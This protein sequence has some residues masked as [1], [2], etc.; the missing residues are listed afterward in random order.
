MVASAA[1]NPS[2]RSPPMPSVLQIIRNVASATSGPIGF[3]PPPESDGWW[4]GGLVAAAM[5]ATVVLMLWRTRSLRRQV[6]ALKALLARRTNELHA[7]T[8][9]LTRLHRLELDERVTAQLAEEKVHLEMLRYQLNPHFLFNAL[10]SI[11][12]Q[13]TQ[14][15]AAA[16]AMVVQLADFCRLT[17]HR[18][19]DG[20]DPTIGGELQLLRAYLD[21]EQARL[22]EMLQVEIDIGPDVEMRRIPPFLLLPLVENAVKYGSATSR[23]RVRLRIRARRYDD[24]SLFFEIANSGTWIPPGSRGRYSTGIGLENVRQ[25]LARYYPEGHE[26]SVEPRDG[27]VSVTLTLRERTSPALASTENAPLNPAGK[28]GPH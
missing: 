21:I 20:G 12:T 17:L 8:G 6:V 24:G 15:P 4:F 27:W 2:G 28:N 1:I 18:P 13:I 26:L 23:D 7:R 5:T 22:G 25:R 19:A 16:R 9:E 14:R 11:C 3:L 10:N